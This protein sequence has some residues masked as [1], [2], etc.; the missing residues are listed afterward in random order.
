M[1]NNRFIGCLVANFFQK[2]RVVVSLRLPTRSNPTLNFHK[3]KAY[4]RVDIGFLW[5]R[6]WGIAV[7]HKWESL[8]K[9]S[10]EMRSKFVPN[11]VQI[12]SSQS[13]KKATTRVAF[14]YWRRRWDSN[15]RPSRGIMISSHVRYDH[16]DT[17]P[18]LIIII[19]IDLM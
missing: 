15:P 12:L 1:A 18:Y 11:F 13:I 19:L 8:G 2:T 3:Q 7:S 14:L 4:T 9:I 17:S 10:N 5:R 6:R 16:F